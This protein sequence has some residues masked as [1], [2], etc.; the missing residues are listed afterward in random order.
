[1]VKDRK[2]QTNFERWAEVFTIFNKYKSNYGY[3]QIV[4]DGGRLLAGPDP[5]DVS[6][7]DLARLEQLWWLPKY[8]H[9]CFYRG[10]IT[11]EE[12]NIFNRIKEEYE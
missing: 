9:N 11:L 7:E 10:L 5:K 2:P 3:Q 1:M 8:E 6:L 4:I 12:L